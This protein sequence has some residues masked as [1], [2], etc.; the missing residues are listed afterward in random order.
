VK[1]LDTVAADETI[2]PN[3]KRLASVIAKFET[4]APGYLSVR[5]TELADAMNVHIRV[6]WRG[7]QELEEAGHLQR[8]NYVAGEKPSYRLSTSRW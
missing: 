2:S 1:W 3:A 4:M 6:V 5:D 7:K 8:L